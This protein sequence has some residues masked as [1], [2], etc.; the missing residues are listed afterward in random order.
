MSSTLDC[1]QLREKQAAFFNN[2]HTKNPQNRIYALKKLY[3]VL[4]SKENAIFQALYKDLK[5]P[6]FEALTSETVL[7]LKEVKLMIKNLKFW[8]EPRK[9]RSSFINFPSK[10]FIVPE[11]YGNVLIISPWNYPFQLSMAPLIGAIAAGNTVVLKPSES[12][13]HTSKVIKEILA[14]VFPQ[15]WVAVVEGDGETASQLLQQKWDYIFFTG[16]ANI[17]RI[18]A[19]TAGRQLTPIT[20]ELGGKSPCIV[21][22]SAPIE[23]TARRIVW[24]K[25]LN[26]GQT[27]IAPDYVLVHYSVKDQLIE[28]LKKEIVAAFGKKIQNSPDYG[29]IIHDKHFKKLMDSLADADIIFTGESNV[30]ERFFHPTLVNE[31]RLDS[32]LMQEEIFGPILPILNYSNT[33]DIARVVKNLEKPLAFYVFST[34]KKFIKQLVYEYSFGGCVVN[35]CLIQFANMELPFGGVGNSGMHAYHGRHSFELF[36][37][38][39]AYVKRSFLFDLPQRYAPYPKSLTLLKK[40]LKKL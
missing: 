10:D 18:V 2:H 21:E 15:N 28:A 31:P 19:E 8:S 9:V 13:P 11:P 39:K 34:R 14:E 25:F 32:V 35:D 27:C 1:V 4:E 40:L 26:C 38:L 16:S 20:L 36:S 29:R 37:H 23:K 24:G 7:I 33:D 5:K 22:Q 12:S 6:P 17:G 3:K 30:T